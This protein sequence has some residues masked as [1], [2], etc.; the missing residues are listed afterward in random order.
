MH[1]H[2][3]PTATPHGQ[4]HDLRNL[5]RVAPLIWTYRGR[6]LL[7]LLSLMA[8][9]LATVGVP[10]LLKH[11]IDAVS[12]APGKTLVLPLAMLVGYGG[13]RFSSA[14][15]NE[16][17][18]AV[19]ARVRFRAMRRCRC[20]HTCMRCRCDSIWRGARGEFRAISNAAR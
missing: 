2:A 12:P 10:L 14:L 13:L 18:D 16:L 6:V 7:A 3:R 9:K 8:A 17:R 20:Y 1:P 5:R 11:I 15:F 19:F 4:R